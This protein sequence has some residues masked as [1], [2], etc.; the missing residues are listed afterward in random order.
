VS[1]KGVWVRIFRP[2]VDGKVV[3]GFEGLDVGHRVRVELV[4][5][6]VNRGFIDFKRVG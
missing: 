4:H 3:S 6:D 5:T 2:P 1:D